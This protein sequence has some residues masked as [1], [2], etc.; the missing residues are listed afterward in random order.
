MESK[1]VA[2]SNNARAGFARA[3][4]FDGRLTRRDGWAAVAVGLA[5]FAVY[6]PAIRL[7]FLSDDFL[8]LM[9]YYSDGHVY[10]VSER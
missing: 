8:I 9:L 10:A 1:T 7:G 3:L 2:F 4:E 6:W 5:A